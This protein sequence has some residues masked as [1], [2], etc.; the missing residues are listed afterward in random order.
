M[1][2]SR[3]LD[4]RILDILREDGRI[5]NVDLAR[6]VGV[7]EKTVRQRITRLITNSGLR[8]TAELDN[9]GS[10][11]KAVYLV[12]TEPGQRLIVADRFAHLPNID[13]V[14][15]T[16]GGYD[17]ILE[18]SFDTDGDALE[19][20]VRDIEA[21][22]GVE[23]STSLHVIKTV[24]ATAAADN[25][26]FAE[27]NAQASAAVTIEALLDLTCDVAGAELGTGRVFAG[28]A[29]DPDS[30]SASNPLFSRSL[31]WRGLSSRYIDAIHRNV[32]SHTIVPTIASRGQH[33]FVADAETNPLFAQVADLV[34]AEQFHSFLSLPIRH[35]ETLL[36]SLN[37]YYDTVIPFNAE[38]IAQGQELA[39]VVGKH[40]ARLSKLDPN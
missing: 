17:I 15:L 37:L 33:L 20:F 35:N 31:R 6:K 11:T 14:R 32:H 23:R 3:E 4:G 22:A 13:S 8:F 5:S 16:T 27:F 2:D 18:A 34:E 10:A 25:D 21:G 26:R 30:E 19:F 7:S 40:L 1:T 12:N 28:M 38:R 36:G 39:D 29:I 24:R 9:D